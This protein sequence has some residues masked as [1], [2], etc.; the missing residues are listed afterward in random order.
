MGTEMLGILLSIFVA[1]TIFGLIIALVLV[2]ASLPFM[3]FGAIIIGVLNFIPFVEIDV[4]MFNILLTGIG[5]SVIIE[6][7]QLI[8][9]EN[10]EMH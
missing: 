4:N 2:I 10:N 7:V 1:A 9:G 5:T 6:I 8:F 3:L